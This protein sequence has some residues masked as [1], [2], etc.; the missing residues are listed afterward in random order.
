MPLSNEP[1]EGFGYG[2]GLEWAGQIIE[3]LEGKSFG[4]YVQEHIFDPLGVTDATF[5]V[6]KRPD[7]EARLVGLHAFAD[8]T[9]T[10]IPYLAPLID[11][12]FESGGGGLFSSAKAYLTVLSAVLAGGVSPTTGKRILRTETVEQMFEPQTLDVPDQGML[13]T[14][15]FPTAMPE[16]SLEVP[17]F[18][19]RRAWTL[20]HL[21]N[22]DET[23]TGRSP[24]SAEWYGLAS[25]FWTIDRKKGVAA[26]VFS[27]TL[28]LGRK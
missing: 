4:T 3:R 13:S 7:L 10:P 28:P 8:G 15:V 5:A 19:G 20:S 9:F 25:L 18:A 24:G 21:T 23:S 6:K 1:G 22:L 27:Q 14:G 11:P 16:M 26:V 2:I 12:E 17:L